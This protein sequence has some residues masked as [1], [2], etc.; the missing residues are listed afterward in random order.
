MPN[1][2]PV[3]DPQKS[4]FALFRVAL[5]FLNGSQRKR[6]KRAG[7]AVAMVSVLDLFGVLLVGW[8]AGAAFARVQGISDLRIPL[9][10]RVSDTTLIV[11]GLVGV[12]LLIVRSVVAWLLNQ[13]ILHFLAG[14][15][16]DMAVTFLDRVQNASF[17]SMS[18]LST[19]SVI[20]GV[21]SGA[22]S[23]AAVIMNSLL[24]FAELSLIIVMALFLVFVDP[25]LFALVCLVFAVTFVLHSKVT[26]P[27][28]HRFNRETSLGALEVNEVLAEVTGLSREERLYDLRSWSQSRLRLA[29]GRYAGGAANSQSWYQFPRYVL[30]LSL[31]FAMIAMM[32]SVAMRGG[33]PRVVATTTIFV[34]ASGRILPSLLRLQSANSAT[35][36]SV[37]LFAPAEAILDLP[38]AEFSPT[39]PASRTIEKP[40]QPPS[41]RLSNLSYRYPSSTGDVLS[42]ITLEIPAG[43]RTA[44]V[45]NTGAGKS[46]LSDMLLGLIEPQSGSIE[47]ILDDSDGIR[48]AFVSQDV[49]LSNRS[50]AENVAIGR[51]PGDIDEERVWDALRSARVDDVIRAMP[52]GIWSVVGERGARVSGGQR[53]R[54]GIARALFR[55]PSFLVLDEATSSLD[56][57][58][59][60]EIGAV[61]DEL[62]GKV[63]IIVIAHRLATVRDADVVVVLE[64]G[65]LQATGTFDEVIERVPNLAQNAKLQ[66]IA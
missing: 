26:T 60:S 30:E 41:I 51:E 31:V 24:A 42:G 4:S 6:V 43:R 21:R 20:E 54:L 14:C 1:R 16:S 9:V 2:T 32:A 27:R 66:G 17:E 52:D 46:T 49:F 56:A 7:V 59:E 62:H 64:Q 12:V 23:L 22:H 47:W 38:R 57:T 65:R 10:G 11:L 48:V 34:V 13:R 45:G 3:L 39:I 35:L 33:S 29:A 40:L 55:N 5:G 18:M 28:I 19:Q 25:I 44:L 53:Q 58:T 37:G 61:L 63:T 8:M 50:I 36:A 15:E